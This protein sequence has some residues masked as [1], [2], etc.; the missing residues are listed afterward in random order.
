MFGRHI[1]DALIRQ[2]ADA[3][4]GSGMAD[5]G[6]EYICID[7]YW[8]GERD[9]AGSLQP[10]PIRFPDGIAPIAEY[11]HERGLKLGMYSDAGTMTCGRQP[12]SFGFER[13]DAETFA[14]WGVDYLKYD[15]CHAPPEREAAIERYT[16]M[17]RALRETNRSIVFAA[18]EWGG[19]AP[20]EWAADAGAHLWRTTG[21]I[22]DAWT[23][24][25]SGWM[26]I[27]DALDRQAGLD[28]YAGRGWHDP[29]ML[30]AGLRGKGAESSRA[31]EASGCTDLEYRSQVSLW[32]MLAAPLLAS[33]DLRSADRAT[34]EMLTNPEIVAISQD[35]LG[36]PGRRLAASADS[37]DGVDIWTR[38][39]ANDRRAFAFLNRAGDNADVRVTLDSLGLPEAHR[40][41]DVWAL[42]DLPLADRSIR[43][44]LEPHATAVVVSS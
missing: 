29:D 34:V 20:W 10:D 2:T 39:L 43:L 42:A 15:Y 32:A 35:E 9:T 28:R 17:G 3:M 22:A 41:R 23:M 16:A 33:C 25:E 26:G 31:P 44:A 36:L 5:A 30:L 37:P 27:V 4:I 19:R 7:D 8:H 21:D 38:E 6:Y 11:L 13:Q 40:L 24:G 12:G 1:D 18:C 14:S